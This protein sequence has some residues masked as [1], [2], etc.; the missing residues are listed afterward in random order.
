MGL[1]GTGS[2]DQNEVMGIFSELSGAEGVV[3]GYS[4]FCKVFLNEWNRLIAVVC[5]ASYL[6]LFTRRGPVWFVR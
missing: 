4:R 6:R 2:P 1:A 3:C 5:Q